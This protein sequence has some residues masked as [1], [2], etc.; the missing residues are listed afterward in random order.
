MK[1]LATAAG[2]AAVILTSFT[3]NT[4]AQAP[5]GGTGAPAAGAPVQAGRSNGLMLRLGIGLDGCTDDWCDDVDPSASVRLVALYR[6]MKYVAAGVHMAFL[7]GE[8]EVSSVDMVW[9]LFLGAEA[10]GI[11]PYKQ[12]D[13]W[14][15]LALGWNR[16]MISGEICLP[17]L[18]CAEGKTWANAVALGFGFGGDYYITKN[19]AVGLTFYLYKPWPQVGCG[20]FDNA[21]SDCD[22]LTDEDKRRIGIIWSVNAMFIYYLPM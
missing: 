1:K 17:L 9:N 2:L 13:L 12:I 8:P 5:P 11:F 18:G 7:F 6:I 14:T 16:T 15:G 20:E 4:A 10:R 19:I 21:D 22:D 3:S